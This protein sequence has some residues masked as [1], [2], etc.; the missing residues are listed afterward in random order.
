MLKEIIKFL[1]ENGADVNKKGDMGRT[2]LEEAK[3]GEV[4]NIIKGCTRL[5][6]S[7]LLR[8]SQR[9]HNQPHLGWGETSGRIRET[10]GT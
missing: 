10:Y 5:Y 9:I 3:D 4:R 6:I 2:A 7:P 1:I 8:F